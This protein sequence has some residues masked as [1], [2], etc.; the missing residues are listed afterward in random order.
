[1]VASI[2]VSFQLKEAEGAIR[3]GDPELNPHRSCPFAYGLV[4]VSCETYLQH[5]PRIYRN[6]AQQSAS[7]AA[8]SLVNGCVVH[9]SHRLFTLH[10][11]ICQLFVLTTTDEMHLCRLENICEKKEQRLS[12][13][14]PL[15]DPFANGIV[16]IDNLGCLN[17]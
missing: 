10:P 17:L 8:S 12:C 13:N 1:M 11:K 15:S 5:S 6:G 2:F 9:S 7:G 14:E 3:I 16:R 4:I